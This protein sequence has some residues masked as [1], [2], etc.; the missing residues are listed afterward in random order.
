MPDQSLQQFEYCGQAHFFQGALKELT[1]IPRLPDILARIFSSLTCI[2][3]GV[4][5]EGPS[6]NQPSSP[7]N[8]SSLCAAALLNLTVP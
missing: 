2:S 7:V 4:W 8:L 5:H 1:Q 6:T 3:Y